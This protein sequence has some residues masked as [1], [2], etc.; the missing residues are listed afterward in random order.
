M[1]TASWITYLKRGVSLPAR[2]VATRKVANAHPYITSEADWKRRYQPYTSKPAA[3]ITEMKAQRRDLH[4][5][6]RCS[7]P[8]A[9]KMTI[10]TIPK[11]AEG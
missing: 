2:Q 9:P 1:R 11:A 3:Q 8:E 6:Y 10:A 7:A 5:W 4:S